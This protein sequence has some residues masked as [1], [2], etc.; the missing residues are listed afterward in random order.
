MQVW[1][2]MFCLAATQ[3]ASSLRM[4]SFM[5]LWLPLVFEVLIMLVLSRMNVEETVENIKR[6]KGIASDCVT[7]EE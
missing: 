7:D 4:L 3:P 1:R 6:E 2:L 5:Y